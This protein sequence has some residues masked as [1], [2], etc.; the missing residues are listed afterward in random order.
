MQD[1]SLVHGKKAEHRGR[2][3]KTQYNVRLENENVDLVILQ[4][5]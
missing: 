4:R 2:Q 1:N 5:L 3:K